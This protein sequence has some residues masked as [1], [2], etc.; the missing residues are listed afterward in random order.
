M[1]ITVTFS[2]ANHGLGC[3]PITDSSHQYSTVDYPEQ[4]VIKQVG[5]D[6]VIRIVLVMFHSF[7]TISGTQSQNM[8]IPM[9]LIVVLIANLMNI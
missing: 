1:Y 9:T 3:E 7:I 6:K 2:L 4:S 5:H 8:I